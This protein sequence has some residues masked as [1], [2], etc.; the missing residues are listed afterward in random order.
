[1]FSSLYFN[2]DK[3]YKSLE[4]INDEYESITENGKNKI[5]KMQEYGAKLTPIIVI[6][7]QGDNLL[8]DGWHTALA[9]YREKKPIPAYV[10]KT[11]GFSL[12]HRYI[13]DIIHR[14]EKYSVNYCISGEYKV[15]FETRKLINRHCIEFEVD[16]LKR[17]KK[18]IEGYDIDEESN[19]EILAQQIN[20][21]KK[22]VLQ[23][24]FTEAKVIQSNQKQ[25]EDFQ[26][27]LKKLSSWIF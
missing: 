27:N 1:M 10:G 8:L 5:C 19:S 25:V 18:A 12:S 14:F 6:Q 26:L 9:L 17:A 24:R 22:Q 2:K 13:K 3:L 21:R 23:L 11:Q 4:D 7:I 16:S 20:L 15:Y